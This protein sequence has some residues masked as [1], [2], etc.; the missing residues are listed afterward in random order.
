MKGVSRFIKD[1]IDSFTRITTGITLVCA[2]SLSLSDVRDFSL[3]SSV[4]WQVLAAGAAT[5]LITAVCLPCTLGDRDVSKKEYIIR[6]SV[7][8]ILI[9]IC[10][11]LMGYKFHWF[12]LSVLS[13]IVM[14][15]SILAVYIFTAVS[16]Y[17]SDKKYSEEINDA[18]KRF[19]E[20]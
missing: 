9:N 13:C 11:M 3:Y 5:G 14:A 8:Y 15:L 1:F 4:L 19:R 17:I 20:K 18:L 2:I 10:I 7:H 12:E 6:Y 16:S